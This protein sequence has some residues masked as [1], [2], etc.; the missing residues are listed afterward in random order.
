MIGPGMRGFS[1]IEV[2][3]AVALFSIAMGLAYGGLNAALR[4]REQLQESG[5]RLAQIQLQ[6]GLLERDVRSAVAR[7]V[8]DEFGQAQP[9]LV[10]DAGRLALTRA[11]AGQALLRR[12]ADLERVEWRWL[13]GAMRRIGSGLLDQPSTPARDAAT[14]LDGVL[15]MRIEA[16]DQQGGWHDQWPAR[17]QA[18]TALPRAVRWRARVDGL[19]EVERLIELPAEIQPEVPP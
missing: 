15:L 11:G 16:M 19:G 6:V 14:E 8:R 5:E 18:P 3:V 1:L 10:L 9:A 13:D 17:G 12:R 4:G 2:V 7:S